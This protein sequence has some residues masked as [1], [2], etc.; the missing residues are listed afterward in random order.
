MVIKDFEM[1]IQAEL[2]RAVDTPQP[3]VA[4]VGKPV[5]AVLIVV[6]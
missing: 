4:R 1:H 3:A 5:V 2:Y 6:V